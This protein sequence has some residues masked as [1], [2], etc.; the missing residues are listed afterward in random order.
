MTILL[1][2]RRA[3]GTGY[4][5]FHNSG[6]EAR[7]QKQYSGGSNPQ[8]PRVYAAADGDKGFISTKKIITTRV[9]N[10]LLSRQMFEINECFRPSYLPALLLL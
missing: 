1:L 2:L 8:H 3:C 10:M 9:T 6:N 4:H 5:T 7:K